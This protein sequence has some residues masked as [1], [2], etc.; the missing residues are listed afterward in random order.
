[1]KARSPLVAAPLA[2]AALCC[3]PRVD[4]PLFPAPSPPQ[5]AVNATGDGQRVSA[6][7]GPEGG[8]FELAASGLRLTLPAGTAGPEGL[9]LTLNRESNDGLPA[10]A[11]RIGDAFRSAPTLAAPSGKRIELRSVALSPLPSSCQGDGGAT[12]ALEAPPEAG[13]GD[14]ATGPALTWQFKPARAETDR[15]IAEL[16]A[17]PPVRAVFLC[18]ANGGSQTATEGT[19]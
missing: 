8:T 18:G 13:P 17:L 2:L 1:M 14:G 11:A 19:K 10:A 12:L 9:S 16:P 5:A 4:P 15:V 3:S 6:H 7:I